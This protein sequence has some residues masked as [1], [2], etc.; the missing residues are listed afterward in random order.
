MFNLDYLL[1]R[2]AVS[3]TAVSRAAIFKKLLLVVLGAGIYSW[4]AVGTDLSFSE[5]IKGIPHMADIISRMLPPSIA[6][7]P[8][9]VEPT[10]ETLQISIWGTTL[11]IILAIPFS[12]MSAKNIS[13]HPL[14]YRFGR[15]ILN[16]TRSISELIWALVFVAAVGLGPFPGV[17]A[18]TFH[19][20]GM[21]GQI[22]GGCH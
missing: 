19:S 11:A 1:S 17:L 2:T 8:H 7:L 12:L 16:I 20:M 4:S 6:V 14:L 18:L 21:L 10:I 5:L 3:G 22:F 13:P 9:L 15:F